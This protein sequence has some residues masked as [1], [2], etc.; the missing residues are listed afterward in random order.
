M[1]QQHGCPTGRARGRRSVSCSRTPSSWHPTL[2]A[3]RCEGRG[4]SGFVRGLFKDAYKAIQNVCAKSLQ[5]CPTLC[6]CLQLRGLYSAM[7]FCP[8]GFS[9]PEYWSG[10]PCPLPGDLPNSGFE[11]SFLMSVL[12][13]GFFTTGTTW[14]AHMREYRLE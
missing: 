5:A 8:W 2:P 11:P 13:G 7:L 10:L 9:R 3:R 4:C 6:Y 12:A 14:E 1:T